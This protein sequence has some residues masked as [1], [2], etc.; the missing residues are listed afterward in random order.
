ML[1]TFSNDE[2]MG[3]LIVILFAFLRSLFLIINYYKPS[4]YKYYT[5]FASISNILYIL[6]GLYFLFIKKLV[7]PL[8]LF[9]SIVLIFKGVLHFFVKTKLY[10]KIITDEKSKSNLLS[11]KQYETF[12][13][14]III[15]LLSSV[16]LYNVF[17]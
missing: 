13:T 7:N 12:F 5:F 8:Y 6:L 2:I 16:V 17:F 9:I 10:E 3:I 15:G 14:N 1:S 11:F 4:V